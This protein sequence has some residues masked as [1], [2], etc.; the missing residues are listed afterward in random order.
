[1]QTLQFHRSDLDGLPEYAPVP[2]RDFARTIKL[3]ANENPYGPSPRALAALANMQAWHYYP[4]QDELRTALAKYV[5]TNP[6][7][8]V[9]S[10]GA[11]ESIDLV[12][13]ATLEPSDVVI[14]C[15]PSFEMYRISAH[16]HRGQVVEVPRRID[17]SLDTDEVVRVARRVGA[18]VI[19]VASPNNPDGGI[20]SRG[21][22]VRLLE[23]PSLIVLDEAYAEFSGESAVGL[24]AQNDNL[25]IL[26]TFSKWAG[27]AGLRV[28]YAVLS[29]TL[30]RAINKLKGPY[31][32]NAAGLIAA[33]ASLDDRE[34]LMANVRAI[35]AE[36][37][38][39]QLALARLEFLH[40]LPSR[41]N[42]LLCRVVGRDADEVNQHLLKRRILVRAYTAA[43][44]REYLRVSIGTREQDD[45]VLAALAELAV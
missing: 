20:L 17:F 26:R 28:G 45:L 39:M 5:G 35:V 10:N 19:I 23:L 24:I 14:D 43:P 2:V 3:D 38:R 33:R 25:V 1:M 9:V 29:S 31:N 16:G 36:R 12:L 42:F 11:D 13:R 22:L 34:H 6:D 4:R 18:K 40:P 7:G 27:L 8:V 44:L 37:E 41:A 21:A 15:P 30:A 32:V